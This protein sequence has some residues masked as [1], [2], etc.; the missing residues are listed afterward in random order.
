[1]DILTLLVPLAA[2]IA[3]AAAAIGWGA[4]STNATPGDERRWT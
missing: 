2:L 4:D 3:F 1:M